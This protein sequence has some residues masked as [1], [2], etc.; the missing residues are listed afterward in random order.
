M[1]GKDGGQ[2]YTSD[3][4]NI[5]NTSL[6]ARAPR[7]RLRGRLHTFA[8]RAIH[9]RQTRDRSTAIVFPSVRYIR[10]CRRCTI[11]CII[12][13]IIE[14]IK[15]EDDGK[16]RESLDRGPSPQLFPQTVFSKIGFYLTRAYFVGDDFRR[17]T[18]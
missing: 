6:S 12:I 9:V 10:V 8:A 14:H 2:Y 5:F 15:S 4:D 1:E 11:Y 3:D 7:A 18:G 17:A 13:T 16:R